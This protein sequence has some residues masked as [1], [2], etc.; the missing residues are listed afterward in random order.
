MA[1]MEIEFFNGPLEGQMHVLDDADFI[2]MTR[3][4]RIR[5]DG[6]LLDIDAR[7]IPMFFHGHRYELWNILGRDVFLYMGDSKTEAKD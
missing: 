1:G 6:A 5:E 3:K 7:D 4:S 2:L